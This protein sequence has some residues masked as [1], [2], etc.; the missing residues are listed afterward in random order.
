MQKRDQTKDG[1]NPKEEHYK[2]YL[3]NGLENCP[4]ASDDA[5]EHE[6]LNSLCHGPVRLK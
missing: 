3:N 4:L 6:N 1:F 2:L 5:M